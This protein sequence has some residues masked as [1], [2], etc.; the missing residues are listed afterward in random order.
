MRIFLLVLLCLLPNLAAAQSPLSFGG[1]SNAEQAAD[2][3]AGEADAATG[4]IDT[5][6]RILEDDT[7]RGELIQRLRDA[8]TETRSAATEAESVPSLNIV[9]Q[10]SAF[11]ASAAQAFGELRQAALVLW[12]EVQR[13][14]LANADAGM[15]AA[16]AL[17]VLLIFVA[18]YGSFLVLR[19]IVNWAANGVERRMKGR[20][21]PVRLGGSLVVLAI[22]AG[23]ILLAAFA[24]YV[25]SAMLGGVAGGLQVTVELLLAAFLIVELVKLAIRALLQPRHL[26]IRWLPL[27]DEA[28]AYWTFWSNRLVWLVGYT[29]YFVRPVLAYHVSPG[30]GRLAEIVVMA[31]ALT[32]AVI[33]VLQN[34]AAT[35]AHLVTI[36]ERRQQSGVAQLLR[37]LALYWHVVVITYLIALFV[38]WLTNPEEALPFMLSA[39]AQSLIAIAFGVAV[40]AFIS[41]LAGIGLQLPPDV[42]TRLPSLEQRLSAFVPLIMGVVRWFVVAIVFMAMAQAWLIFDVVGW[43]ASDG[44][45]QAVGSVISAAIIIIGCLAL[46]IAVS[47]W[48]EFRLSSNSGKTPTAREKTLLGLFRNAFTIALAVF[49]VMLALAQIGVNIAPL[50][51]GAGVIGLAIGFGA[52]KLVEDIITGIFIQFENVM[53]EGDVVEAAGRSGVVE[54]LTI[55]S[56][57][58]RDLNGTVH[59]IPFS[60]VA[61]V[62]NM[63]RGF[64]FHVAEVGVAY[65]SDINEVKQAMHD[66]FDLLM[67]TEHKDEILD[68]LDMQGVI[69]F[70]D[71]AIT[72][73]ARIK[74]LPG[75]HWGAGRTYSE[76]LKKVFEERGIEIPYPH[77]TY[78]APSA[79]KKRKQPPLLGGAEG[80]LPVD[81]S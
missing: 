23:S 71:S 35:S 10:F 27:D 28:A 12:A 64:S 74:T 68:E 21:F 25:T 40:F 43:I 49:G 67:Q 1:S 50:L 15:V 24:G 73:R 46:Y 70:A 30:V 4:E 45:A 79:E 57:T 8:G 7:A 18:I 17:D 60:S 61:Q 26:A 66:A 6:I 34:R 22:D 31:A 41:R 62:S 33:I 78:V 5:L 47:S 81:Q 63:V 58:I 16:T 20:G 36:A 39:T 75:K 80:G 48:I 65:D 42:K 32:L 69:A 55:R 19:I 56:V 72:V 13:G 77:V 2:P 11:T 52:Q 3:T 54:K 53:N 51:A 14:G 44:G 59:L 29:I 76:I 9:Q 37:P 38:V